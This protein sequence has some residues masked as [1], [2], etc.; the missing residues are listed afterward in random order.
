MK[1]CCMLLVKYLLKTGFA[2]NWAA[3]PAGPNYEDKTYRG[4]RDLTQCGDVAQ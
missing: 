2:A 4:D 3:C 1:L